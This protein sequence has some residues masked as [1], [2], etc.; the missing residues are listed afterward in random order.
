MR[1]GTVGKGLRT[2]SFQTST[3]F[4]FGVLSFYTLPL[5]FAFLPPDSGGAEGTFC[6]SA[7]CD[8]LPSAPL[9]GWARLVSPV[10]S[11]PSVCPAPGTADLDM[12][13]APPLGPPE[14]QACVNVPPPNIPK[15]LSV[16]TTNETIVTGTEML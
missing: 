11:D 5:S 13:E 1:H 9:G 16:I 15:V 14:T 6:V 12:P 3:K 4:H 7:F 10:L 8:L 2:S